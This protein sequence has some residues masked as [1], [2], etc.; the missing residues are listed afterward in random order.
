MITEEQMTQVRAHLGDEIRNADR[1]SMRHED[2]SAKAA[3]EIERRAHGLLRYQQRGKREGL[4]YALQYLSRVE[5]IN[6]RSLQVQ[7]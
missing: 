5:A 1:L 7:T 6:A 3:G 4:Q 2:L